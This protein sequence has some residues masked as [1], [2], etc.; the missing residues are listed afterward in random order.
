MGLPDCGLALCG[1]FVPLQGQE[2][3]AEVILP[4]AVLDKLISVLGL[5]THNKYVELVV[6]IESLSL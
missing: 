5:R 2:W 3:I 6:A 1:F 4:I